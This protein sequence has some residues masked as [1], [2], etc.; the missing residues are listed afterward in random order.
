MKRFL[1]VFKNT[2]VR[3]FS[4][5]LFILFVASIFIFKDFYK[6]QWH[7]TLSFYYVYIGDNAYK[8]HKPQKAIESYVKALELYPKHYRAQY[9]LGNLYVVYEDYYS[10][11]NSYSKAL[12]LKPDFTV[13]RINY[14]IVLS[15]TMFNYDRAI[16]EYNLAVTNVPKWI[17]IPFIVNKK[18]SFKHNKAV[19][20]Y[21]QG[22]AWR[23]KSLLNGEDR[24]LAR[25]FLENAVSSYEKALKTMKSFDVYYNLAIAHHLLRNPEYAGYYYCKAIE[26]EP[27]RYEAH[28]NFAILLRGMKKYTD[29]MEEFKKAGLLLDSAGDSNKTRYIYDILNEVNQ[30][31]SASEEYAQL[32]KRIEEEKK[33]GI[34]NIKE[35]VT[36]VKGKTLVLEES[37]GATIKSFKKCASKK[38][39]EDGIKN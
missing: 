2:T 5:L 36:Y 22:L 1:R 39:F 31:Y 35:E 24:F 14:A 30:K 32:R 13:A 38:Y 6:A 12:Q 18:N 7:K 21:N 3:I 37:K 29:S 19:A 28:Y 27:M 16:E 20:F 4:F 15:E 23:G 9:N 33:Q 11:L 8:K 10:A 34:E 17:Y 26:K 25:R